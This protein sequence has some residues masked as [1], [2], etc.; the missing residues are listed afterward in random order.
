M[1]VPTSLALL[2]AEFRPRGGRRRRAMSTADRA[3]AAAL[4]PSLGGVLVDR[5]DWRWVFFVDIP[6]GV[7]ALIPARRILREARDAGRPA[8]RLGRRTC[9]WP[10][11]SRSRWGSSGPDSGWDSTRVLASLAAATLLLP[12]VV[13][14]SATIPRR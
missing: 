2:L 11:S 4:G 12:V 9:S 1:L 3:V 13:V 7:A 8:R 5:P 6:I 14:R 10:A